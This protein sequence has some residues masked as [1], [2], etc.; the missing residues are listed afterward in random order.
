M[1]NFFIAVL[2]VLSLLTISILFGCGGY[3][4]MP[5]GGSAVQMYG[6]IDTGVTMQ[7]R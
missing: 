5:G 2:H 3:A 4:S 1:K 7:S 6:T